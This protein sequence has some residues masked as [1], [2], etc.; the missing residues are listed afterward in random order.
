LPALL[1]ELHLVG[2]GVWHGHSRAIDQTYPASLPAPGFFFRM[3]ASQ[4]RTYQGYSPDLI[5][6]S[7]SLDK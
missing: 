4:W 2:S 1:R 7:E 3:N 5:W 6:N